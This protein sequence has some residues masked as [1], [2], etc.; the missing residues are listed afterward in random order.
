MM[1]VGMCTFCMQ[2]GFVLKY[3][4]IIWGQLSPKAFV[5]QVL[6]MGRVGQGYFCCLSCCALAFN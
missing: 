3:A 6:N 4:H 5:G 2:A 1:V